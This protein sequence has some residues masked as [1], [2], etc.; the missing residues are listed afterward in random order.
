MTSELMNNYIDDLI[1]LNP[2]LNDYVGLPKFFHLKKHWE[3]NLSNEHII[4]EKELYQKYLNDMK[5]KR[6]NDKKNKIKIS[7]ELDL[8]ERSF[9]YDLSDSL[10]LINSPTIYMPINHLE[11]PIL[12][13]VELSLGESLYQFNNKED[14][15]W[16]LQKTLEF[17]IWCKTAV[18]RMKEGI[19]KKYIL[20]K[21]SVV[22]VI[23]QLKEALKTKDYM[24]QKPKVKVPYFLFELDGTMTRIIKYMLDFLENIYLKHAPETV[25]FHQYPDG[26]KHYKMFVKSE[27]GMDK[28]SVAQIHKMGVKEVNRIYG[29]FEKVMKKLDFKG[30]FEEFNKKIE[31]DKSLKYKNKAEMKQVFQKWRRDV[32]KDIMGPLFPDKLKQK[33]NLRPVPSY[34]EDGS[35]AAYYMPGDVTGTRK[36][37]F[38][39][40]AQNPSKT[41]K[42]ESE[43]LYLHEDCPGH[44]YQITLTNL[45]KKIPL[46]IRLLD[47]NAY[48]E[49]WGLYCENLGKYENVYNYFGKLNMEMLRAIRLVV[50]TGIHYYGWTVNEC[51]QYFKQYSSLPEHEIESEIYRYIVDPAQALSY[52]IGEIT[53]LE[54]REKYLKNKKTIQE[55]HHDV[56][57]DGPLPLQILKEKIE[58]NI[59]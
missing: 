3:N 2:S 26:K 42:F 40:N 16:F 54:L 31:S 53:L 32:D 48:I 57:V 5:K 19:T 35:P 50:D 34:M 55:F 38:Y 12:S 27:T 6:S 28:L 9:I 18:E 33:S 52:K 37:T 59:K 21:L 46:F 23:K 14:Y 58:N 25:G 8:W 17:E 29:E 10:Q 56:L 47:N 4:L 49:G 24:K 36:G 30:S 43:S 1:K 11:N 44:H 51:L 20:P 45:N 7:P 15:D 41:N 13:Y 39:F 22:R